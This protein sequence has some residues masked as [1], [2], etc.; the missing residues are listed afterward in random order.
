[1]GALSF[2][3]CAMEILPKRSLPWPILWAGVVEIARS[4]GCRLRAYRDIAG[5]WTCGWGETEGVTAD[6]VWT[7]DE[8][9]R[10]L[11][12]RL[13]EFAAGVLEVCSVEPTP[14]QEAAMVSLAYNVGLAAFGRSSVLAAHNRGDHAAAARAFGLWNKARVNGVLQPVRGLT[15][16]R[17]R[18]AALYMEQPPE[19][20]PMLNAIPDALA[21]AAIDMP[22]AEPESRLRA[23]PVAQSGA[24][25]MATGTLAVASGASSDVRQIADG[26]GIQPLVIVGI[27]ALV[28]GGVVLY[29]RHRQRREGWA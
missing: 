9:D 3:G 13:K 28:A 8:A 6:T 17:M 2:L 25:S 5:V 29:W 12:S 24:V 16:R 27:V 1:M 20:A 23:S 22:A 11:C 26:M 18:E 15:A 7:Q 4:E 19:M 10:R 21:G 14:Q